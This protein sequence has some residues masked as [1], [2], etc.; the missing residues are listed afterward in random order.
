MVARNKPTGTGYLLPLLI[1]ILVVSSISITA[2]FVMT[3][4]TAKFEV[5][6]FTLSS[7]EAPV[8]AST[9][10]TI[11]VKN[12]GDVEG[13]YNLVVK[14]NGAEAHTQEVT[15]QPSEEKEIPITITWNETGTHTLECGGLSRTVT[16]RTPLP[17]QFEVSNLVIDPSVVEVG[18]TVEVSVTL[19]NT[20]DL[21]GT[22]T[23][24]LKI[25]DNVEATREI[26]LTGGATQTVSFMVTKD[27]P[28]T[29]TIGVDGLHRIYTVLKPATFKL[30]NL[31]ISPTQVLPGKSA[32]ISVSVK[33]E[34]DISSTYTVSLKIDGIT[35]ATRD[36]TLAGGATQAVSFTV[37][38][39]VAQTY[40]VSVDGL[41][42]SFTVK[43]FTG[44]VTFN[45]IADAYVDYSE[46]DQDTNFGASSYLKVWELYTGLWSN[47]GYLTYL[48]FDLSSIPSDATIN[49]AELKL[50]LLSTVSETSSI[51]A[52]Y[53][54][55]NTWTELGITWNNAPSYRVTPT[56]TVSQVAFEGWYSWV[57]T[58]DVRMA[59]PNGALSVALVPGEP[60][61]SICSFYSKDG[62]YSEK[63]PKLI[64]N[65][66]S[67]TSEGMAEE[68]FIS[69]D[70]EWEDH[71]GEIWTWSIDVEQWRYEYYQ[72]LSHR[73]YTTEDYLEF[74]TYEDGQI[75]AM[76]DR[77]IEVYSDPE[78]AAN[79]ILA[80]VQTGFP[81]TSED[82]EY[83][84]YP[85]ETLVDNGDCEDKAVL[86][87]AIMKAAGYDVA[88]IVFDEHAMA[89]VVLWNE[90]KYGTQ[91][92]FHWF[93]SDGRRYYTCE[94]TSGG[95]RVGDL[96]EEYDGQ[97]AYVLVVE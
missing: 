42:G 4:S 32:K 7:T 12:V 29:Y 38:K 36:V 65:Y 80:F 72:G 81:Y 87:A 86:F 30:T 76:A 78:D 15:L 22:H 45:P 11:K 9:T 21:Q 2:V 31:T 74:V 92:Y 88:L 24:L 67:S 14:L 17:A 79:C 84:R 53:V 77:L 49:S 44:T 6:S 50:Y 95:W 20:G 34:G 71:L 70:F 97:S 93:T 1:G 68:T 26:T 43:P 91:E 55:S 75:K 59:L 89:G 52:H 3:R 96:P 94:T 64:I 41:V 10:G 28:R 85:V 39:N 16:I 69:K 62:Y 8:G 54:S 18:Q 73:A 83:W 46:D 63:Q 25:N 51:G 90:P 58:G 48:K 23:V 66:T 37:T 61:G 47:F 56:Y 40:N 35:E 13:T 82:R 5:T 27:T 33:N 57:I 19:T 60:C